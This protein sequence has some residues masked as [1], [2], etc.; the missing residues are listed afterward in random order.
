[1]AIRMI[2]LDLDG[3]LLT[4]DKQISPRSL[5]ALRA[6]AERGVLIVPATGR[7]YHGIPQLLK[8]PALVRYAVTI[9]GA[10]VYDAKEDRALYRAEISLD[11]AQQV[12]DQLEQ[13]PVTLDCYAD[14]RGYMD[15]RF[16]HRLEHYIASPV[17]QRMIRSMR[18][19][20]E[21]F[22]S[23]ITRRGGSLQKIQSFFP[24]SQLR[25]QT[26]ERLRAQFPQ[27]LFSTSL[28][29]NLEINQNTA[30]KGAG[31]LALCRCLDIPP[32]QVMALGDESNDLS[33]IQAAGLGV[34][35]GN[36]QQAVKDAARCVTDT[37]DRDGVAR[38]IEQWVL[39]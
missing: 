30:H 28:P 6:A 4:S 15:Q 24:N 1:M 27:L 34:A 8:D 2:L 37:N 29:C 26:M 7:F 10:K 38:A 13:L 11:T 5:A 20:V 32:Q 9:N 14:D 18:E 39:C 19:P 12:F 22:R 31:L 33:M 23:F 35:M 3:T 36:A 25:D 16:Y 21:D 17:V